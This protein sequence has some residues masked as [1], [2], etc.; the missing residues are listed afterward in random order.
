MNTFDIEKYFVVNDTNIDLSYLPMLLRRKLSRVDKLAFTVLSKIFDEE[1]D[2]IIFSSKNGEFE[3]LKEI[4]TQYQSENMVSPIKFSASVHNFSVR[5]FAQLNKFTRPYYAISAGDE[6]FG[7]GLVTAIIQKD[8]KVCYC[9]ADEIGIGLVVKSGD[10]YS[11][12]PSENKSDTI[13]D[14]LLFMAG[15]REFWQTESGVIRRR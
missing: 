2:E 15:K 11:L 5:A 12:S 10:K 7:N 9:Y 1:I 4:I 13:Y 6:S 8:K 3:R 14:F